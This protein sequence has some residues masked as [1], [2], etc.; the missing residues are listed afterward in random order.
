MIDLLI[1]IDII[2]EIVKPVDENLVFNIF[3]LI[4]FLGTALSEG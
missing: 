2:T 1:D 3:D 4:N